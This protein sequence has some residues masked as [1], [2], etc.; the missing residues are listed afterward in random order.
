[1]RVFYSYLVDPYT[2]VSQKLNPSVKEMRRDREKT[3]L[4]MLEIWKDELFHKRIPPDIPYNLERPSLCLWKTINSRHFSFLQDD[5][6]GICFKIRFLMSTLF[7]QRAQPSETF[8]DKIIIQEKS[9]GYK[10]IWLKNQANYLQS[11]SLFMVILNQ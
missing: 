8:Q 4:V 3:P 6:G 11:K 7:S 2:P 10:L 9:T 1:M 5:H